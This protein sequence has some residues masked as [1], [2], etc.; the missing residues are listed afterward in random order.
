MSTAEA[1]AR[2]LY[3][4]NILIIEPSAAFAQTIAKALIEMGAHPD[5]IF[6]ARRWNEAVTLIET[7]HPRILLTEYHIDDRLGMSLIEQQLKHHDEQTKISLILTHNSAET[8]VAAAAEE[9]VDE[10]VLKPFSMGELK[11]RLFR[12]IVSKLN[13]SKFSAHIANGRKLIKLGLF[14]EATQEFKL[15]EYE[16]NQSPLVFFYLG[17]IKFLQKRFAEAVEEFKKGLFFQPKHYKCLMGEFDAYFEQQ[18]YKEAQALLSNIRK[19]YPLSPKRLGN[20]IIATVLSKHVLEVT[21]FINQYMQLDHKPAELTKIYG[22]AL[23]TAGKHFIQHKEADEAYSC[24]EMGLKVLGTDVDFIAMA[25][26]EFIK[27]GQIEHADKMLGRFPKEQVGGK[28]HSQLSFLIAD[29]I[30][31]AQEIINRGRKLV[32]LNFADENCFT[33]LIKA[34]V[35]ENKITMA[36]DTVQKATLQYPNQKDYFYNLLKT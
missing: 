11:E 2:L 25:V 9:H 5:K 23:M 24:F 27:I 16:N 18:N 29:K 20:A 3:N 33:A 14:T 8:A 31:N 36:E 30:M 21:G 32:S 13:P 35:K 28:L 4:E 22:A 6:M 7:K 26:K 17:Q 10:Y 34:M 19:Q 1:V 15:A 12:V